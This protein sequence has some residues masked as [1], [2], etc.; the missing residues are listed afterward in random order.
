MAAARI[1]TGASPSATAK[2][3]RLPQSP[4]TSALPTTRLPVMVTAAE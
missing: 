4:T 1:H 2:S 3:A